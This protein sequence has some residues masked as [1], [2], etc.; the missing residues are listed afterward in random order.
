MLHL[1][2]QRLADFVYDIIG[3][4]V[5]AGGFINAGDTLKRLDVGIIANRVHRDFVGLDQ[6]PNIV[7]SGQR[8]S[9]RHSAQN[10]RFHVRIRRHLV[11]K[12]LHRHHNAVKGRGIPAGFKAVDRPDKHRLL[13]QVVLADRKINRDIRGIRYEA[14]AVVPAQ[15]FLP[16][17]QRFLESV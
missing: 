2:I 3:I 8:S 15:I 14:D 1:H 7:E 17:Q 16:S 12:H 9:L 11:L 13:I 5:D 4:G 6:F 10:Q